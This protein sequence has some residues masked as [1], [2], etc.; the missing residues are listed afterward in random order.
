MPI[1]WTSAKERGFDLD[2]VCKWLCQNPAKL[3]GKENKKGKIEK[4]YD[5]DLIVWDPYKKFVVKEDSIYHRHKITAYLNEEL[6][7]VVEQTWVAG[8]RAYS[9]GEM[10]LNHGYL[11]RSIYPHCR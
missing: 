7:G 2:D 4:G 9:K 8:E 6:L 1:L 11:N 10:Q 3:I 5:A